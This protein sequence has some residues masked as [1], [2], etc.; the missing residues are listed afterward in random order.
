M[1]VPNERDSQLGAPLLAQ[2]GLRI[3]SCASSAVSAVSPF[4]GRKGLC[5]IRVR[6]AL[7]TSASTGSVQCSTRSFV[8]R[9]YPPRIDSAAVAAAH[10]GA[11]GGQASRIQ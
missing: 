1:S 8:H 7:R 4:L 11:R 10:Y 6:A 5:G 9:A 2:T 3:A